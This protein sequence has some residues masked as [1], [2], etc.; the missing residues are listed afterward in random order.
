MVVDN[1]L[2]A[3]PNL[4]ARLYAGV[5]PL[6]TALLMIPSRTLH[7]P[8]DIASSVLLAKLIGALENESSNGVTLKYLDIFTEKNIEGSAPVS[9]VSSALAANGAHLFLLHETAIKCSKQA[10]SKHIRLTTFFQEK[11]KRLGTSEIPN[12]RCNLLHALNRQPII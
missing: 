10:R 8:L 6:K 9:R 3:N 5:V 12:L 11:C 4:P 2:T 1:S 7:F